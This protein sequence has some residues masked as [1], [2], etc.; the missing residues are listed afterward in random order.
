MDKVIL[1]NSKENCSACCA[2]M[3][4]CP[5]NAITM[6]P[7]EYGFVYPQIDSEI[8]ILCGACKSVCSYQ[9]EMK[10]NEPIHVYAAVNRNK[11]QLLKSS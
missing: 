2:C 9:L 7:D 4:I 10:V 6:H 3:N 11:E 1:F 5:I 8:C